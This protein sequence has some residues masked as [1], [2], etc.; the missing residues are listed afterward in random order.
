[1]DIRNNEYKQF[2]KALYENHVKYLLVG[3]FAVNAHGYIRGT[4]DLD[5][6]IDKSE[7]NLQ[8][9]NDALQALDFAQEN[10]KK[11]IEMLQTG[12]N[13]DVILNENFK[14]DVIQLYST[15][16]SFDE[17]FQKAE[18]LNVADFIVPLF[19][20][21]TLI[22]SKISSGRE[23]DLLDVSELKKIKGKEE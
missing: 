14:I 21:D 23:R 10:V 20:Y 16:I 22:I 6:W 18:K 15:K 12:N 8:L 7:K 3:G 19:D 9:F 5:I 17:A 1:M 4:L 2:L 13:V 11:A